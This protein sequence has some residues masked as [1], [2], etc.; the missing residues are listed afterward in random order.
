MRTSTIAAFT[1][2]ILLCA[3]PALAKIS[4]CDSE[5][6]KCLH[7]AVENCDSEAD[8]CVLKRGS[9]A[10]IT[11][12]FSPDHQVSTVKPLV[13]GVVGKFPIPFPLAH[14]NACGS[15]GLECPLAAGHHYNYT[16]AVSVKRMY[17]RIPVVVLW[18]L[19]DGKGKV[20]CCV[21]IPCE[22]R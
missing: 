10:T 6:G 5:V 8:H 9:K 16:D 15:S 2:H 21:K 14:K 7:A 17:P 13:F 20:I 1:V 19:L 18:K 22:I 3:S 11:I 4:F 12:E